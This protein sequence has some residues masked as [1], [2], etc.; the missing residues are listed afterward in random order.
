MTFL[1][2]GTGLLRSTRLPLSQPLPAPP[3]DFPDGADVSAGV[4]WLGEIWRVPLL[5]D[6]VRAASP[7]LT[8]AVEGLL[9]ATAVPSP[10]E[11]RRVGTAVLHYALRARYRATPF[12][13][14]AGT[15]PVRIG[16]ECLIPEATSV[17]VVARADARWLA[18]VLDL[19]HSHLDVVEHLNVIADP[20][21][22]VDVDQVVV[23]YRPGIDHPE[24][25][26]A[27]ATVPL[28]ILLDI[29]ARPVPV[30]RMAD[31]VQASFPAASRATVLSMIATA[32]RSGLLH[33]DLQPSSLDGFALQRIRAV[34]DRTGV[35]D[36][37]T[38]TAVRQIDDV[39]S[40]CEDA[41]AG[42]ALTRREHAARLMRAMADV[43]VSPLMLDVHD[44][45]PVVVPRRL[46]E[47]VAGALDVL[48]RIS[49]YPHGSSGWQTFRHR[50]FDRYSLGVLVP[51]LD[52]IDPV[53]GLGY[54]PGFL[55]S[56]GPEPDQPMSGR[57]S[58]LLTRLQEVLL[59]G[60]QELA[61]DESDVAALQRVVPAQ[62]WPS[63]EVTVAVHAQSPAAVERGEYDLFIEGM[64]AA[65]GVFTGRFLPLM[66]GAERDRAVAVHQSMPTLDD[67]AIRVQLCSPPLRQRAQ[68]LSR[69]IQLVPEVLA[70]G[71]HT[72]RATMWLDEIAVGATADRLYLTHLPTGRRIEPFMPIA[73][74][75]QDAIDPLARFLV[76]LPRS[77][78]AILTPYVWGP[79][80]KDL[81]Y[82]PRIRAGRVVLSPARWHVR[83]A[84]LGTAEDPGEAVQAWRR[85]W[86][87]PATVAAGGTDRRLRLDLDD[88]VHRRV[89]A[90]MVSRRSTPLRVQETPPDAAHGWLGRAG[91]LTLGFTAVQP[92]APA[93]S[94]TLGP[95]RVEAGHTRWPGT[96]TTALLRIDMDTTRTSEIFAAGLGDLL[97]SHD[98]VPRWWFT[99]YRDPGRHLRVRIALHGVDQFG[100]VAAAVAAW[101]ARAHQARL[102][103]DISWHTDR[104]ET[105]RY[106]TGAVLTAAER[107]FA[108][109]SRAAL[110][111]DMPGREP[112]ERE[113]L[114]V[115]SLFD[116][117]RHVLGDTMEALNLW[118]DPVARNS[119]PGFERR[120]RALALRLCTDV[121]DPDL[122][123]IAGSDAV[124]GTWQAR[125]AALGDYMT[126]VRN[127]G[128]TPRQVL[129][130]L[131]HLHHVRAFGV[132]ADHEQRIQRQVREIA[133]S[134]LARRRQVSA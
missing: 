101:A 106:G 31:H 34:L 43:G 39:L 124:I 122:D 121:P 46:T 44:P 90:D 102:V 83:A 82:L 4:T 105:G 38:V 32:I 69:S 114:L 132:D 112:A 19:L 123:G 42:E 28:R 97:D 88:P 113:G 87:V 117:T 17:T 84:D 62:V 54:P 125:A 1:S 72:D 55:G 26:R 15:A 53:T 2:T 58:H 80:V 109:D 3:A 86:R 78:A 79:A 108:A 27:N 64:G 49:D 76:E 21:C 104:P 41:P 128:H 115:A 29:A 133:H 60:G 11:M 18:A 45:H 61:L 14:F 103:A 59:D 23:P 10:E 134:L 13:L 35:C 111:Q 71:E 48:T 47:D 7:D 5:A 98:H 33:S 110:A 51:V 50:F 16:D 70:L 8:R 93:P 40:V 89:L 100:P 25:V 65:A 30:T 94:R 24:Q 22:Q 116:I 131:L 126:A 120:A 92:Q 6:A 12:G 68:N 77:H 20:T 73:V 63:V 56:S 107:F 36:D 37:A 74:N 130:A 85:R 81:P 129:P 95:V 96:A 118:D 67:E 66:D 127:A 91:Q 99:R 57:D 52:L 75:Q 119:S 9:V